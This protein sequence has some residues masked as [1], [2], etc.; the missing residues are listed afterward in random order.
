AL[1]YMFL[2]KPM[3]SQASKVHKDVTNAQRDQ[4]ALKAQL[5]A[6]SDKTHIAQTKAQLA[7]LQAAI[8][9]D[10]QLASFLRSANAIAEV[11]GVEWQ[12][13]TPA[14]PTP[15]TGVET[16]NVSILVNGTQA[17]VHDYL[18]RL[19]ALPRLVIV[20]STNLNVASAAA[21]PGQ[22]QTAT[23]VIGG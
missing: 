12:T 15:S 7:K 13:I 1:W 9:A 17:E 10:P 18:S 4:L 3:Q 16:V 22:Q 6:L 2:L 5:A 21:T 23:D 8:P 11:S 14:V 19:E 20:D